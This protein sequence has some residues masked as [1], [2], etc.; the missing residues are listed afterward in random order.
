MKGMLE[1]AI[2]YES[3]GKPVIAF[4][5]AIYDPLEVN[6]IM[7]NGYSLIASVRNPQTLLP[8]IMVDFGLVDNVLK[9]AKDSAVKP[10]INASMAPNYF[11]SHTGYFDNIK[12]GHVKP[13]KS[14]MTQLFGVPIPKL[15]D[16]SYVKQ[17]IEAVV[18]RFDFVIV[19][20]YFDES[21]VILRRKMGWEM[22]DVL[23]ISKRRRKKKTIALT[24]DNI[25]R[26]QNYSKA[27]YILYDTFKTKLLKEEIPNYG[28]I[29]DELYTFR[30]IVKSF[31]DFCDGVLTK[32]KNNPNVI[33][34]MAKQPEYK[35]HLDPFP[36][37]R[38][39]DLHAVECAITVMDTTILNTI[40]LVRQ[41][42]GVCKNL[43]GTKKMWDNWGNPRHY[44]IKGREHWSFH[45]VFCEQSEKMF[46]VPLNILSKS[47]AYFKQF[48]V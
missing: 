18:K 12:N 10:P 7:P 14:L 43:Q 17:H 2:D 29:E 13:L 1:A 32:V 25:A 41:R 23:Y 9:G 37:G 5:H 47:D 4:P 26:L 6:K 44:T 38:P 33:Y 8:S 19:N 40:H 21:M 45:K 3:N 11:L 24:V 36:W 28:P 16:I 48:E 22:R 30:N 42:P 31:G 46:N 27:D 35:I 34:E 39:F 20:E 15:D